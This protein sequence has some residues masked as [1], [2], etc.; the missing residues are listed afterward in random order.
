MPTRVGEWILIPKMN[1]SAA[2]TRA[3]APRVR[4]TAADPLHAVSDRASTETPAR[5]TPQLE[6][7]TIAS[8]WQRALDADQV[9]LAAA[10]GFLPA[11]ELVGRQRDLRQER[12][13]VA[14]L[15]ARLAQILRCS[16]GPR[17]E[18][19]SAN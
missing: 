6:L 19:W 10:T 16:G 11:L 9:A 17:A 4:Q 15:L 5:P 18:N 7:D 8:Q 13:E 3:P 2:I 14:E 12:L 1:V